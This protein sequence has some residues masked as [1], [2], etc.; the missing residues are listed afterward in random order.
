MEQL[1]PAV[2]RRFIGQKVK[3]EVNGIT[4]Q[5]TSSQPSRQHDFKLESANGVLVCGGSGV[6]REVGEEE[7]KIAWDAGFGGSSG[8]CYV[9]WVQLG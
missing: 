4:Y 5:P 6:E 1:V 9:T 8:G 2:D 3:N 7:L